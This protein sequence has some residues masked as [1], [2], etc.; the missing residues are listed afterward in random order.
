MKRRSILL[1]SLFALLAFA[2]FAPQHPAGRSWL[3]GQAQT[4]LAQRGL[5][6]SFTQ[7]AGNPWR[8]VTLRGVRLTG[9]DIDVGLEHL[10]LS[11]ALPYL[12]LGELPLSVTARGVRGNLDVNALRALFSGGQAPPIR[13]V[14]G[15]IV[16]DEVGLE[17]SDL[18][19]T[20]PDLRVDTPQLSGRSG[21][22]QGPLAL[23]TTDGTLNT[24]VDLQTS[25]FALFV[26]VDAS[27]VTIARHWW[28]GIEAGTVTGT[29]Y[30]VGPDG[31]LG[32]QLDLE[33]G[34]VETLGL[35]VDNI[36]G[37]FVLARSGVTAT[38]QGDTLGD[39]VYA[40]AALDWFEREYRG[41]LT[42][43]LDI[44]TTVSNFV[45]D[46]LI[47]TDAT[48]GSLAVEA[49]VRGWRTFTVVAEG[50][51][52]GQVAGET[53]DGI[54]IDATYDSASGPSRGLSVVAASDTGDL[55][56]R[57][58][59]GT[60]IA[61]GRLEVTAD[62]LDLAV[63]RA[64]GSLDLTLGEQLRG[65][66]DLNLAGTLFGRDLD[67]QLRAETL[68]GSGRADSLSGNDLPD[69][70]LSDDSDDNAGV[71]QATV[72]GSSTRDETVQ[73]TIRLGSNLLDADLRLDNLDLPG[74]TER[75]ALTL[76]AD[77]PLDNLP[78]T[79]TLDPPVSLR[80]G[81]V[82]IAEDFGG[83]LS[84][85]LQGTRLSG[86]DGRLGPL[87]VRGDIDVTEQ[88]GEVAFELAPST[89]G[90]PLDTTLGLNGGLWQLG[91][92]TIRTTLVTDALSIDTLTLFGIDAATVIDY[93]DGF[94][95]GLDILLR[96]PSSG[97]L[98]I[99]EGGE[100]SV[101]FDETTVNLADQTVTL[102]GTAQI[103]L[104][105][106]LEA[107]TFNL[108]VRTGGVRAQLQ[109]TPQDFGLGVGE[110]SG[111]EEP[112]NGEPD[113]GGSDGGGL[114]NG[115][116][117][118]GP[119]T[120]T[121]TPV[122]AARGSLETLLLE[123]TSL[124]ETS[125]EALIL[126]LSVWTGGVS[127]QLQETPQDAEPRSDDGASGDGESDRTEPDAGD[128]E[129]VDVDEV[130]LEPDGIDPDSVEPGSDVEPDSDN[131][132]GIDLGGIS[133]EGLNIE[134]LGLDPADLDARFDL[135][136]GITS[137]SPLTIE[138][139][140]ASSPERLE[141]QQVSDGFQVRGDLPIAP[142]AD[143]FEVGVDLTGQLRADL[144][145]DQTPDGL[146]YDGTVRV[147]GVVADYPLGIT[148]R[149]DGPRV[150]V[151]A[152]S[153]VLNQ[154]IGVTGTVQPNLELRASIGDL[155]TLR[156]ADG[157]VTGSG[158]TPALRFGSVIIDAL[159]W[160]FDAAVP[161]GGATLHVGTDEA[162]GPGLNLAG[163]RVV[164]RLELTLNRLAPDA[165]LNGQLSLRTDGARTSL[166]V[167]GTPLAPT[168]S[169]TI[170][171]TFLAAVADPLGVVLADDVGLQ[172][173]FDLQD[174]VR[175]RATL[176]SA[177]GTEATP[178]RIDISGTP[179]DLTARLQADGL[180]AEA[181]VQNGT[182]SGQVSADN[183]D[184][185][186]LVPDFG[187][188]ATL[189]GTL[190]Y[191]GGAAWQ[192][193]LDA[194]VRAPYPVSL[195]VRGAG[196]RLAVTASTAF[197]G[198]EVGLE[199]TLNRLAPNANLNGQLSLRTN[200]AQTNLVITGTLLAPTL[201]GTIPRTLLATVADPL[202]VILADDV[203]LQASFNVQDGVQIRATL[204]SAIGSETMPTPLRID[205][206]GTPNDLIARLQADGLSA[207]ARVQNGTLRGQVSADNLDLITLAPEVVTDFG[208][209]ATLDG[210]LRYDDG[211]AWQGEL[212]ATVYAPYPVSLR[213][214]GEGEQLTVTA[215]NERG[216]V[217]VDVRGTVLPNLALTAAATVEGVARFEG[218][219]EDDVLTGT[220]QT[221]T[222]TVDGV[223]SPAQTVQLRAGLEPP[224]L[225][226]SGDA[227][228]LRLT[229]NEL[230][231]TVAWPVLLYGEP[232]LVNADISGTLDAPRVDGDVAGPFVSGP[233]GATRRAVESTL[234]V[235]L[236]QFP[237][238]L[239]PVEVALDVDI[240]VGLSATNR[241]ST[242]T[243][244]AS[245]VFRG[246]E[247]GLE[248]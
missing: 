105:A 217:A 233:F 80:I 102:S 229:E 19:Y 129:D 192:G 27:D 237:D 130:G 63:L 74:L 111:G 69:D 37:P 81:S 50:T 83:T 206:S 204:D 115:G 143:A 86:I 93:S 72:R 180:S 163:R 126:P 10:R 94:G 5:Q 238:G 216:P 162:G 194:T 8:G 141:I 228:T 60:E 150:T 46:T 135:V 64:D 154:N 114:G 175:V 3:L 232:H 28:R 77:G 193:E 131:P 177:L 171:R 239:E 33:D 110:E 100:L 78:L 244:T 242:A 97:L 1:V 234:R 79:L 106:P 45:P 209:A 224:Q 172:A 49:D 15:D 145:I 151:E 225:T 11:Y 66:A 87:E 58:R 65:D 34:V 181:R 222:L 245:T 199:L 54:E 183:L 62:D 246:E 107:S 166:A 112:G 243:V 109:G 218:S 201:T 31:D 203:S 157:R 174:G 14:L 221:E 213:V 125:L 210:T 215:L 153:R 197:R 89:L 156:F 22:L 124:L 207:E 148:F 38:L 40:D 43:T 159:P 96:D 99:Y 144:T 214:R 95:A 84:A 55:T 227:L 200:G 117:G 173:S 71:W 21:E 158:Q 235:D 30:V 85:T 29:L 138:A 118:G 48:S 190:R 147:D 152:E 2:W 132:N 189:D 56:V 35:T 121:M 119:S 165:P 47:P 120:R 73:G 44:A 146:R 16:V 122:G 167:S 103:S 41:T 20:L 128:A 168:L 18:P 101:G 219:F 12:V 134:E 188:A 90:G 202:G 223:T 76:S 136:G 108:S 98:V 57:F 36:S 205:I 127:A 170:P 26:R 184:L 248:L 236:P 67:V 195:R 75:S 32:G 25:P 231:G 6:L 7:S 185:V 61:A 133:I 226:L 39:T 220:L 208:V 13:P 91:P 9:E 169:G 70:N 155:G 198:A 161:T 160:Q 176:D 42:G 104:E 53:V 247:V 137:L 142:L 4:V 24:N 51:G 186:T 211:A 88:T 178:L 92:Q 17:L 23:T 68:P 139:G 212:G 82:T 116:F 164:P 230:A 113:G 182:L 179:D 196:E 140:F 123:E 241:P 52:N 187:V 149:G 240:G 59:P 191:D